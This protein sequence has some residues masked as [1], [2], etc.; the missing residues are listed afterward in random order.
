MIAFTF[1]IF[2]VACAWFGLDAIIVIFT[3]YI[4]FIL[5][6]AFSYIIKDMKLR[7][8][9]MHHPDVIKKSCMKVASLF[10][11]AMI[12]NQYVVCGWIHHCELKQKM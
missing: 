4:E 9:I 8:R 10:V 12:S 11:P 2:L 3:K 1:G 6:F 5:A 7:I